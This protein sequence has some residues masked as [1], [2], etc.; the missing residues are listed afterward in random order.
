MLLC[1]NCHEKN[2]DRCAMI[3]FYVKQH[4]NV[5]KT[6]EKY[7]ASQLY[8]MQQ[9]FKWQRVCQRQGEKRRADNNK[10]VRKQRKGEL[11]TSGK[12]LAMMRREEEG[13]QLWKHRRRGT[14]FEKKNR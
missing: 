3:Q 4:Y 2:L 5:M 9:H 13:W 7:L 12:D 14:S 6:F 11:F 10:I 1:N 8:L